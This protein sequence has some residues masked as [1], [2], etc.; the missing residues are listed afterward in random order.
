MIYDYTNKGGNGGFGGGIWD[1]AAQAAG[2]IPGLQW[3]PAAYAGA[4]A[5]SAA[6]NGDAAGAVRNGLSAFMG[7]TGGAGVGT[8]DAAPSLDLTNTA[9]QS[10][11]S[12]NPTSAA[13]TAGVNTYTKDL[14]SL[15]P[16]TSGFTPQS[17]YDAKFAGLSD[18]YG[19]KPGVSG[20]TG[21]NQEAAKAYYNDD[22]VYNAL[23]RMFRM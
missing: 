7:A 8:A 6:A 1:Y 20:S 19:L 2:M 4:K 11:S 13:P 14:A 16:V 17:A 22:D 21:F 3:V 23:Q 10:L 15:N 5:V 18:M 12:L 9:R